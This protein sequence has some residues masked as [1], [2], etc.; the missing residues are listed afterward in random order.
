MFLECVFLGGF[1]FAIGVAGMMT[2]KI[3]PLKEAPSQRCENRNQG[4]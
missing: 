4:Q 3:D 1:I 2:D